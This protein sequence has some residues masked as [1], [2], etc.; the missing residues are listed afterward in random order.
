MDE[1][2][3]AICGKHDDEATRINICA[4]QYWL[5]SLCYKKL[6]YHFIDKIIDKIKHP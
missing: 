2:K 4:V 1:K 3:C 6:Y 5:C